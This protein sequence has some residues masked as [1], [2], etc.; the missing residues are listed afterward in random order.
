MQPRQNP[1]SE[2][3][4]KLQNINAPDTSDEEQKQISKAE[5]FVDQTPPEKYFQVPVITHPGLFYIWNSQGKTKNVHMENAFGS[6]DNH[7]NSDKNIQ[8]I[9]QH[10]RLIFKMIKLLGIYCLYITNQSDVEVIVFALKRQLNLCMDSWNC[11]IN[12]LHDSQ[13]CQDKTIKPGKMFTVYFT[14]V[15]LIKIPNISNLY[16]YILAFQQIPESLLVK[17]CLSLRKSRG[18]AKSIQSSLEKRKLDD[19]EEQ[20]EQDLRVRKRQKVS[21]PN[22]PQTQ[23]RLEGNA[24][25]QELARLQNQLIQMRP[26]E[27]QECTICGKIPIEKTI[28]SLIGY[29]ENSLCCIHQ[30]CFE[31]IYKWT[32]EFGNTTCPN[33]RVYVKKLMREQNIFQPSQNRNYF[34]G[35]EIIDI[36]I[37]MRQENQRVPFRQPELLRRIP[38]QPSEVEE[39]QLFIEEF[40]LKRENLPAFILERNIQ[41]NFNQDFNL[42][43]SNPSEIN[44][45]Q[46]ISRDE[47]MVDEESLIQQDGDQSEHINQNFIQTTLYR[48][49][50]GKNEIN[51]PS[52]VVIDQISQAQQL[53]VDSQIDYDDSD[54]SELEST[55]SCSFQT[56]LSVVFRGFQSYKQTTTSANLPN[57][58]SYCGK[59]MLHLTSQINN[60]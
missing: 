28:T 39:N 47:E 55:L 40:I 54:S 51:P 32:S 8:T 4:Q 36:Q 10:H 17:T 16:E 57:N 30:F 19:Q 6:L 12:Q 46:D 48:F 44:L 43:Q 15:I 5:T 60:C 35:N 22:P 2:S 58:T 23:V 37:Q 53:S 20:M 41:A 49:F 1:E 38:T 3:S 52:F 26:S 42:I 56:I 7:D 29:Q 9:D 18:G 14:N 25:L 21:D 24:F 33:C 59:D 45:S 34:M 11:R 13:T 50:I 27:G 31:C